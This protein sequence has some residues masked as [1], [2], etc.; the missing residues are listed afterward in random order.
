MFE[1]VFV[2]ILLGLLTSVIAL[3]FIQS[4]RG[5]HY[6][7]KNRPIHQFP[8]YTQLDYKTVVHV[9]PDNTIPELKTFVPVEDRIVP[10]HAS[11]S[12]KLNDMIGTLNAELAPGALGAPEVVIPSDW[13]MSRPLP[14][15]YD[16]PMWPSGSIET[17]FIF[18]GSDPE[19]PLHRYL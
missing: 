12:N 13:Y 19:R 15:D 10:S 14:V 3:L 4:K 5:Y 9:N 6:V 1:I 2:I 11:Y 17:D 7:N 16:G 8:D 18:P